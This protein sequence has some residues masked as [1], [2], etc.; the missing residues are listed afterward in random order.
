MLRIRDEYEPL[1]GTYFHD[2]LDGCAQGCHE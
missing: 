2:G 1:G